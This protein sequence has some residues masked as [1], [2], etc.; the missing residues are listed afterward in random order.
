MSYKGASVLSRLRQDVQQAKRRLGGLDGSIQRDLAQL[1]NVR[2]ELAAGYRK[3]AGFYLEEIDAQRLGAR[4]DDTFREVASLLDQRDRSYQ[5]ARDELTANEQLVDQVASEQSSRTQVRDQAA[6]ALEDQVIASREQLLNDPDFLAI[7]ELWNNSKTVHTQATERLG[8]AVDDRDS[9]RKPYDNDRIFSY[10]WARRYGTEHYGSRGLTRL[11]DGWLSEFIDYDNN[12]RNFELLLAIP[13]RLQ[14]HA[15]SLQREIDGLAERLDQA[16]EDKLVANG[17]PALREALDS[18][19]QALGR[20]IDES[21]RLRDQS[22]QLATTLSGFEQGSDQYSGAAM[23]RQR[24]Q[25][26]VDPLPSLWRR[27]RSTP[28]GADDRL[29]K[30]IE[31]LRY[32]EAELE[33]ELLEDRRDATRLRERLAEL[34]AVELD[35]TR[36]D[37]DSGYSTFNRRLD[38]GW[39]VAAM[40]KGKLD[41]QAAVKHL[42]RHQRFRDRGGSSWSGGFGGGR[43]RSRSG[44]SRSGGNRGGGGGFGGFGGGGFS[45]GG[46]FGGGGFRTGGGF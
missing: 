43:S 29:V 3:L 32:Q 22:T 13:D 20:T 33:E 30:Q 12:S 44:R 7:R 27:A 25:F 34:Q 35:F 41:R 2:N 8:A 11:F 5:G 10:L 39:L 40:L 17:G 21:T 15:E 42:K 1:T 28:S 26:S 24:E 45:G 46:G 31:R 19:E 18:A 36:R 9:K 37:W 16:F 14:Q 23:Q 38:I 4:F 6:A